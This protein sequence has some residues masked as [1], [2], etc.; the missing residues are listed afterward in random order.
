[1]DIQL[2][3][4]FLTT[5]QEG[6][7]SKAA[8]KLN[9]AQSNVTNK[10]QQLE[11]DLKTQLFY[12]HNR[13]ITITP[14]G[15]VFV[16][17][18]EKILNTIQEARA[19]LSESAVPS[20]PLRIGSMETTAAIWLPKILPDYHADYPNVDL[21]LVTGPTE[22]HIHAILHYELDGAFVSGPIDHPELIQDEIIEEELVLITATSHPPIASIQ[23]IDT[24]TMLVFRKGCSYRAKFNSILQE[25]GI[26]PTKLMEFGVM[27]AIIGCVSAGLGVSLLP[28]SIV[29]LYEQQGRVRVHYLPGKQSLVKTLFIRRKDTLVTPALS[30]FMEKMRS[31]L[32]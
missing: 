13:G 30:A 20:G 31:K 10:I 16:S 28:R 7:I 27:E 9:Y 26:F 6:S 22:Q 21:S 17:Y 1:M 2:L 4:V 3:R 23:D 8:K 25:E 12:R 11:K 18:T 32:G 29:N 15:Q 24:Y 19:V 5:A 14:S